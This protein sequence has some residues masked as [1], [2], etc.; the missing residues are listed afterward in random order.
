M[1]IVPFENEIGIM[2]LSM[3]DVWYVSILV[4]T[5]ELIVMTIDNRY[6]KRMG[7]GGN[8]PIVP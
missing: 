8:L 6:F 4:T 1:V 2:W 7:I 5:Y 3:G